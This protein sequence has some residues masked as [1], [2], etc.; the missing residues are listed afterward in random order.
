[1][2]QNWP[3]SCLSEG[4]TDPTC[5]LFSYVT[6]YWNTAMPICRVLSEAASTRPWQGCR[7]SVTLTA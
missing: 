7:D 4:P 5:C 1:M 2:I 3:H 6:F